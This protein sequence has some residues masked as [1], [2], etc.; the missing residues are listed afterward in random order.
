MITGHVLL[1]AVR[2]RMTNKGLL[3][4]ITNGI[5]WGVPEARLTPPYG[6]ID[7]LT[8]GKL[9]DTNTSR[10]RRVP[11]TMNLILANP[12]DG[13]SAGLAAQVSD[14]L[15]FAP[16]PLSSGSVLLNEDPATRWLEEDYFWHVVMDFVSTV[17]QQAVYSPGG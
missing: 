5:T 10:L 8:E 17:R 1:T 6:W 15:T 2:T 14:G 16:L 11:W 3:A 9:K 7:G 13:A 12:I 4:A